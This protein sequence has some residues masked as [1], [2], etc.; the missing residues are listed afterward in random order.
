M[1]ST[2]NEHLFPKEKGWTVKREGNKR[3]SKVFDNKGD[4]MDYVK[5]IARNDGRPIISQKYNGQFK[6]F[7]QGTEL[8]V[9]NRKIASL[10][11]GTNEFSLPI[12][13]TNAPIA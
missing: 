9:R 1:A 13:N 2:K 8:Y 12:V 5:T 4:A 10:I 6:R 11:T 7:K 3:T